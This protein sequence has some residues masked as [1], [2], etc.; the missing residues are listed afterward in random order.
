MSMK[1]LANGYREA[2]ALLKV[3]LED[4][5]K[6]LETAD[7]SERRILE[8]KAADLRAALRQARDLRRLVLTYYTDWQP[9]EYSC[10]HMTAPRINSKREGERRW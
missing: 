7:E 10:L 8:L 4:V 2:A 9:P 6:R 5:E 3:A 1:N